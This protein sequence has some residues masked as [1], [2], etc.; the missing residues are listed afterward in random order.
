MPLLLYTGVSYNRGNGTSAVIRFSPRLQTGPAVNVH[1]DVFSNYPIMYHYVFLDGRCI[2]SRIGTIEKLNV[3]SVLQRIESFT[4]TGLLVIKQDTQW[5]EFYCREGRLLCVGPIRTD[6]TLGERLLQDRVISSQ[7]LQETMLTIGNAVP[8]ETRIALTLMDLGHVTREELRTWASK[9]TEEI[10]RVVLSW[11]TGELYFDEDAAPPAE[12]LLVSLSISVLLAPASS[13]SVI[14]QAE[15]IMQSAVSEG[16]SS[17]PQEPHTGPASWDA[18]QIATLYEASQFFSPPSA[19][20]TQLSYISAHALLPASALATN[21]D[22]IMPPP[23]PQTP[24]P[25]LDIPVKTLSP[26]RRVDT[27]LMQPNMVLVPAD[28]SALPEQHWQVTQEQWRLLTRVDGQTSLQ[29]ACVALNMRAEDVCRV[30]GELIAER[31]VSLQP[32]FVSETPEMSP[33]SQNLLQSGLSNG[34]AMPGYAAM[35]QPPWGNVLPASDMMPQ[36]SP[37]LET[38]SQWGNGGNGATFVQGQGWVA[39]METLQ[40]NGTGNSDLYASVGGRR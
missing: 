25:M 35:M 5:V 39:P 8:S 31:I 10:L 7:S 37:I 15:P 2:V 12:R 11:S 18:S 40:A 13:I 28:L 4:K 24:T 6:A 36:F 27:F 33:T 32:P 23:P 9:K 34:F 29:D 38:H 22:P 19:L 17:A 1:N 3:A 30:V 16:T 14:R 21:T 20:Q 26:A